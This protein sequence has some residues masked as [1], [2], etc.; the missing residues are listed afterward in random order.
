MKAFNNLSKSQQ[1][2]RIA[3]ELA[4]LKSSSERNDIGPVTVTSRATYETNSRVLNLEYVFL[5]QN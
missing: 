2:R 5:S 1:N 4:V 3:K